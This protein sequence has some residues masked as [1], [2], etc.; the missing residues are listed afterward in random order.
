MPIYEYSCMKCGYRFEKLQKDGT[1][2]PTDCPS[3]SSSEIK[4]ELST[5]SS[6]GAAPSAGCFSGG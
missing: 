6:A 1:T 5:F 3:C 2:Q 4:R